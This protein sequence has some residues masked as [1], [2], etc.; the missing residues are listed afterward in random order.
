MYS[1]RATFLPPEPKP[2]VTAAG[3]SLPR[4]DTFETENIVDTFE[5]PDIYGFAGNRTEFLASVGISDP[6]NVDDAREWENM[7]V[8]KG[9]VPV[10]TSI[11]KRSSLAMYSSS[12]RRRL[13]VSDTEPDLEDDDT[14]DTTVRLILF[15]SSSLVYKY[16]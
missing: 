14:V 9:M 8:L 4:P 10:I 3:V 2:P 15:T 12:A 6:P 1:D 16:F 13:D 7:S 11:V 5:L